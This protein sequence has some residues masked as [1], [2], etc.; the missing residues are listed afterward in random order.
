MGDMP[1]VIGCIDEFHIP[2]VSIGGDNVELYI[3]VRKGFFCVNVMGV[4]DA[5]L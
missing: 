2:I 4:C 5:D 1:G 3:D